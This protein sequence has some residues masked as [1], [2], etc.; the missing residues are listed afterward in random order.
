MKMVTHRGSSTRKS[1]RAPAPTQTTAINTHT[2]LNS[3]NTRPPLHTDNIESS[4]HI[5]RI[6][7]RVIRFKWF[8][9]RLSK[10]TTP[11][12]P[13]K[14]PGPPVSG[15]QTRLVKGPARKRISHD[16]ENTVHKICV[17]FSIR[18]AWFTRGTPTPKPHAL[19]PTPFGG[20]AHKHGFPRSSDKQTD[21]LR[22][23]ETKSKD[24]SRTYRHINQTVNT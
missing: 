19:P 3:H 15:V 21:T 13:H 6:I 23:L 12:L 11:I 4:S 17:P 22:H 20:T 24:D 18:R 8:Q 7:I 5:F 14:G 9:H 16:A 2:T 1:P 10:N